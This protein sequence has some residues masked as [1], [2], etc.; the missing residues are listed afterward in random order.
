ML[1]SIRSRGKEGKGEKSNNENPCQG[2]G[3]KST[4]PLERLLQALGSWQPQ[5]AFAP[6]PDY[7]GPETLDKQQGSC[8]D[9]QRCGKV[10]SSSWWIFIPC[11]ELGTDTKGTQRRHQLQ[12]CST[13]WDAQPYFLSSHGQ[14]M[15]VHHLDGWP[16][17]NHHCLVDLCSTTRRA[18]Q[19]SAARHQAKQ[20]TGQNTR[21]I[22]S[23][24][25]NQDWLPSPTAEL[26]FPSILNSSLSA[27]QLYSSSAFH[28]VNNLVP[29]NWIDNLAEPQPET[30]TAQDLFSKTHP[31]WN[32]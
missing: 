17:Q 23:C 25:H 4:K 30:E 6:L 14:E 31:A 20:Q 28:N 18:H 7:F 19:A 24:E 29:L 2:L 11:W 26:N 27:K 8:P 22:E 3:Q 5:T 15:A 1:R 16:W 9:S 10:A 12:C 32:Q 13:W 21:D